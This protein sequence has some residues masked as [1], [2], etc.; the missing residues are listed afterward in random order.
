MSNAKDIKLNSFYAYQQ[1]CREYMP[2]MSRMNETSVRMLYHSVNDINHRI[3]DWVSSNGKLDDFYVLELIKNAEVLF[4]KCLSDEQKS[5]FRDNVGVH[6][7]ERLYNEN[8]RLKHMIEEYREILA[9]NGIEI[10]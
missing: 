6:Q 10:D 9:D 2:L 5:D 7:E 3:I 4:N 1:A 8:I